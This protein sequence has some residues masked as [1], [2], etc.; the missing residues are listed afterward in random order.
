MQLYINHEKNVVRQIARLH[1]SCT[2]L[3]RVFRVRRVS[4]TTTIRVRSRTKDVVPS[5]HVDVMRVD[6][7]AIALCSNECLYDPLD[8][9]PLFDQSPPLPRDEYEPVPQVKS[10]L[11]MFT[12]C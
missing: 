3:E 5:A 10:W 2:S 1:N 7:A 6:R 8:Y 11:L 4:S 12:S 9:P